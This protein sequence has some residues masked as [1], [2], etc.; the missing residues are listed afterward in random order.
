MLLAYAELKVESV[1]ENI[2]TAARCTGCIID[3][4]EIHDAVRIRTRHHRLSV[5]L[6]RKKN[7]EHLWFDY[8]SCCDIR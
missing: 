4:R 3:L 1:G 7:E 2:G 5:T 6:K 8:H